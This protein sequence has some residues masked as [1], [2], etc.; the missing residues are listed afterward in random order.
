MKT[1]AK[2]VREVLREKE[3]AERRSEEEARALKEELE[4]ANERVIHLSKSEA[5]IDMYKRKVEGTQDLKF[6][7]REAEEE[8]DRFREQL[9]VR[10]KEGAADQHMKQVVDYF[11]AQVEEEK[12]ERARAEA[13]ADTARRE[14]ADAAKEKSRLE[15]SVA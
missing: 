9:E 10:R 12:R 6:R 13:E 15:R 5:M 3:E 11:K 14:L 2:T 1:K 7:L 4:M 8:R